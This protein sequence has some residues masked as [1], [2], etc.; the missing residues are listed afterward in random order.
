MSMNLV[1]Q[2]VSTTLNEGSPDNPGGDLINQI[3]DRI[4]SVTF[5]WVE[6]AREKEDFRLATCAFRGGVILTEKM[7][8]PLVRGRVYR[9]GFQPVLHSPRRSEAQGLKRRTPD[10]SMSETF[11]VT[12]VSP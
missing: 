7:P 1:R 11:R 3:R 5:T 2:E 4:V 6:L 8:E 9:L 10:G 12:S